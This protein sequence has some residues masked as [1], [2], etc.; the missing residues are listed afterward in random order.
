ME[1]FDPILSVVKIEKVY[2]DCGNWCIVVRKKKK[3]EMTARKHPFEMKKST[4]PIRIAT[5]AFLVI[6][7]ALCIYSRRS[8]T[9]RTA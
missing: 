5:A 1:L 3:E 7:A 8:I 4:G 2:F 6:A 9:R